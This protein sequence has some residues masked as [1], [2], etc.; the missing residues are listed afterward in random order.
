MQDSARA[1]VSPRSR[2][3]STTTCGSSRPSSL[4]MRPGRAARSAAASASM[5]ALGLRRAVAVRDE[6]QLDLPRRPEDRGLRVLEARVDGRGDL[7]DVA[8]GHGRDPQH[9][10]AHDP[11]RARPARAA[12]GS[13]C[14]SN[15]G[16][17]SPGGP[18]SRTSSRPSCSRS[19][20]GAVPRAFGRAAAP[21]M[22]SACFSF[23]GGHRPPEAGEARAQRLDDR[24]VA[25]QPR[26]R[27]PP[28]PPRA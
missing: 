21:S 2:S 11:R 16:F 19:W 23:V 12:A 22:T 5:R 13:T 6:V 20:P 7:V 27:P 8:L 9:A 10:A 26:A 3:R 1:S 17:I 4:K 14:S 15:I 18:G 25:P 24:G 28:P